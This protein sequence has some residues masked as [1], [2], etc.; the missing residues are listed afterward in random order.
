MFSKV[1]HK[2]IICANTDSGRHASCWY[3]TSSHFVSLQ[4][5]KKSSAAHL[6]TGS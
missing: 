5:T 2:N 4:S 3:S 1:P 6:F